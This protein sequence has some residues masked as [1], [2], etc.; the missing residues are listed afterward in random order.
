M[1]T[2]ESGN[3]T[4]TLEEPDRRQ[5]LEKA[6]CAVAGA[7]VAAAA[8]P[9]ISSMNPASDVLSKSIVEVD[10]SQ[11]QVDEVKT[12]EWQSKPVFIFRRSPT[13]ISAMQESM[14]SRI[15]PQ[16]D[17]ERVLKPEWLVVIGLCTHLGCV[18]TKKPEGWFCPCHGSRYDN[19]GRVIRGPAPKNLYLLPYQFVSADKL[20]LGKSA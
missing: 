10:I 19:S 2:S 6:T 3:K 16:P 5:F 9:F 7:G 11:I 4:E 20:L 18:P 15:D 13:Q 17:D 8:W 12:V 1:T 14:G